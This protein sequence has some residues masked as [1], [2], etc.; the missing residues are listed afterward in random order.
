MEEGNGVDS[1]GEEGA[2]EE[3]EEVLLACHVR[4]VLEESDQVAGGGG[5]RVR[6]EGDPAGEELLQQQAEIESGG[7]GVGEGEQLASAGAA[8]HAV[9]AVGHPKQEGK[10][11]GGVDQGDEV[12]DLAAVQGGGGGAGVVGVDVQAEGRRV[13]EGVVEGDGVAGDGGEGVVGASGVGSGGVG[14]LGEVGGI[15]ED[16]GTGDA[17]HSQELGGERVEGLGVGQ[18]GG[19]RGGQR[20]RGEGGGVRSGVAVDAGAVRTGADARELDVAVVG[21]VD[22]VG[23]EDGG[24]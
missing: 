4:R 2:A 19:K 20:Q 6:G 12:P 5:F 1:A 9:G 10:A 14:E 15:G 24:D 16:V 11:A 8:T 7:D 22:G 21:A 17:A 13:E 3:H 23:L 18:R